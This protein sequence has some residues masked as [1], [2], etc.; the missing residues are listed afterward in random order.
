MVKFPN[1]GSTTQSRK[2]RGEEL[3]LGDLVTDGEV[4]TVRVVEGVADDVADSVHH[5]TTR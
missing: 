4:D 5:T 2:G 3:G 1:S